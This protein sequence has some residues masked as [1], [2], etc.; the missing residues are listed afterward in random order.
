MDLIDCVI[1]RRSLTLAQLV[2]TFLRT[3]LLPLHSPLLR[4][5]Q[6]AQGRS[7]RGEYSANCKAMHTSY[8]DFCLD[9]TSQQLYR[10]IFLKR[11]QSGAVRLILFHH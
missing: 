1:F 9:E 6:E 10:A 5:F 7:S 8:C 11:T 3:R 4:L 2:F